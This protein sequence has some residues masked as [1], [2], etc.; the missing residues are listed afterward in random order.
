MPIPCDPLA[1][2]FSQF[3]KSDP[4]RGPIFI[5]LNIDCLLQ[6]R[7]NLFEDFKKETWNERMLLF[8]DEIVKRF[9]FI[10]RECETKTGRF[11]FNFNFLDFK[12]FL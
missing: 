9:G 3:E 1:S 12:T 8:Q 7:N 10:T 4:L 11:N 2:P 6:N 5:S